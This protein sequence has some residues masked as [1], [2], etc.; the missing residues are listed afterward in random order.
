MEEERIKVTQNLWGNSRIFCMIVL[1]GQC[2][3]LN[4]NT[5]R[6]RRALKQMSEAGQF[7]TEC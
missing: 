7:K 3:L 4:F 6:K 1:Q 5:V 2:G